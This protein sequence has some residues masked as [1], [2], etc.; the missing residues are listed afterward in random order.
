MK[1]LRTLKNSGRPL[2]PNKSKTANTIIF[3]KNNRII[4]D[5]KKLSHTNLTKTVKLKKT[6]PALKKK[7]LKHLLRRFKKNSTKKIKEHFNSKETFT[8]REFK[9]CVRYFFIQ[10]LFFHQMIALQKL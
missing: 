7:S 3:H 4:K 9:A 10:F 1:V 5:N 6:S 2:F 8:F